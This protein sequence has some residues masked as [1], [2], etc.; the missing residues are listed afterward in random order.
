MWKTMFLTYSIISIYISV[1]CARLSVMFE[2]TYVCLYDTVTRVFG[3]YDNVCFC[4]VDW[5]SEKVLEYWRVIW[6][7][8]GIGM[9]YT[10]GTHW[11]IN[12]PLS[13]HYSPLCLTALVLAS[14]IYLLA[15]VLMSPDMLRN[16]LS[17]LL[18]DSF[19]EWLW[20]WWT[21]IGFRIILIL[22]A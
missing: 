22:P 12:M 4:F 3:S 21:T 6:F 17:E 2:Y 13:Q 20:S 7:L 19:R 14:I 5:R 1:F 18:A 16:L 15:L 10:N 9:S 11:I 8:W